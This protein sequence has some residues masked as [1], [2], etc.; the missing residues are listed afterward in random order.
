MA[1]KGYITVVLTIRIS[2]SRLRFFKISR[3]T[4][5]STNEKFVPER[6]LIHFRTIK[7]PIHAFSHFLSII[8]RDRIA[9]RSFGLNNFISFRNSVMPITVLKSLIAIL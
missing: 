5:N 2:I 8:Q 9:N 6:P 7:Q 3:M 4:G 1:N